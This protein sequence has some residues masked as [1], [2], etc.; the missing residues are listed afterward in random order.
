MKTP[1]M[2]K[3]D[4]LINKLNK[5]A[6]RMASS[7]LQSTE[8][9]KGITAAISR[10]EGAY[11]AQE[12]ARVFPNGIPQE[13]YGNA[14]KR[15]VKWVNVTTPA[16]ESVMVPQISR[17][18][19]VVDFVTSSNFLTE[20]ES[21]GTAK[22]EKTA[23]RDYLE[24]AMG[25]EATAEDIEMA[26][27]SEWLS[28]DMLTY[29]WDYLYGL[30]QFEDVQALFDEVT[31]KKYE[32]KSEQDKYNS[33][34]VALY[35]KYGKKNVDTSAI[36]Q[37]PL[38]KQ[39]KAFVWGGFDKISGTYG[40]GEAQKAASNLA[41]SIESGDVVGQVDAA[42]SYLQLSKATSGYND[43]IN[44]YNPTND[45]IQELIDWMKGGN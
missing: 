41:Q 18:N 8:A 23:M 34:A 22:K 36:R 29:V 5:R 21:A 24:V 1:E 12:V 3:I 27:N 44:R 20:A 35:A 19:S 6:Y 39:Q 14:I 10:M 15:P 42:R 26:L 40:E 33:I 38:N 25:G 11:I 16:G 37:R 17:S 28:S 43:S 7:G 31:G 9:Y 32:D 45:E 4:N 2:K 30:K 13:G